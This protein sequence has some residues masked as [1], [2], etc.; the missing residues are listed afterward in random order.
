MSD[1]V[2][3]RPAPAEGALRVRI[4]AP[5]R[6]NALTLAT[7]QHL[8]DLLGESP[9][10]TILIGSTTD[11]V[12]SAGADLD[13][14]DKSRALLSDFLYACY[15]QIVTRPGIVLAVVEGAA[16]GGGAQ[17]SAAADVRTISSAARW[18][19]VGPGHGLAVGAWIVPA[20]LGRSRGLDLTL[21]S[22]WLDARE[23]V[24]AGFAAGID[25]DPWA[26]AYDIA[27]GLA[28][29][30]A[31]AL[32]RVKHIAT[33]ADLLERLRRERSEN[34]LSWSGSAPTAQAASA[35]SRRLTSGPMRPPEP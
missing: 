27:G 2:V 21:T 11:S 25:D 32:A 24:Q 31:A 1:L 19:W 30:D 6:R 3:D 13:I 34:K 35:E 33:H 20:L 23:A 12:F 28:R 4:D 10:E 14:D 22:R 15:E 16:V 5:A 26:R 8:H 9:T 7:V 17:L 29:A 18:R